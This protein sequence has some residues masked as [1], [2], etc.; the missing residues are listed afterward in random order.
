MLQQQCP[1]A[2]KGKE[3]GWQEMAQHGSSARQAIPKELGPKA[4]PYPPKCC[5]APLTPF[6]LLLTSRRVGEELL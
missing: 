3:Q 6:F 4:Q 2:Q 5:G 1:S